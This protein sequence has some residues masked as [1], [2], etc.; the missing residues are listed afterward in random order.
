MDPGIALVPD[1]DRVA[2]KRR[3]AFVSCFDRNVDK[4]C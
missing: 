4:R 1:L 3:A 2:V